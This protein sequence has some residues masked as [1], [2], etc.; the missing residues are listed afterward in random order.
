MFGILRYLGKA[1]RAFLVRFLKV[2]STN[3]EKMDIK[4]MIAKDKKN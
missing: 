3:N 4:V 1:Y 2:Q